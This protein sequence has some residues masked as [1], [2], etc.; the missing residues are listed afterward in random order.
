MIFYILRI[1]TSSAA[2]KARARRL[3]DETV[4]DAQHNNQTRWLNLTG[5]IV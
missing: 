2:Q 3:V 5:A 4:T 1:A